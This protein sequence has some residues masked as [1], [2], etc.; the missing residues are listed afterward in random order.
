MARA[1]VVHDGRILLMKRNKY[2][3]QFYCLPGGG[4]ESGEQPDEVAVRE[5]REETSVTAETVRQVYQ[6]DITEFG[7][8]DY[9]LCRY[10]SGEPAVAP[11]AP[12]AAANLE[13][14]NTYEPMWVTMDALSASKVLPGEVARRLQAD[15]AA[16]SWP[17]DVIVI[18]EGEIS[19][20]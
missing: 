12:E 11:S 5:L 1:I 6:E 19:S 15:L 3:Q 10:I 8:S 20:L 14:H 4:V 13:G 17:E 7:L 9:F 18:K 2:G 16:G